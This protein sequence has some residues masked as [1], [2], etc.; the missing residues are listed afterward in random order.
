MFD[1]HPSCHRPRPDVVGD[2]HIAVDVSEDGLRPAQR[3]VHDGDGVYFLRLDSSLSH[4]RAVVSLSDDVTS[5]RL[6]GQER[7]EATFTLVGTPGAVLHLTPSLGEHQWAE[8]RAFPLCDV[9]GIP[10]IVHHVIFL[11]FVIGRASPPVYIRVFLGLVL[12]LGRD[13]RYSCVI[14]RC[15]FRSSES[16]MFDDFSI[17]LSIYLCVCVCVRGI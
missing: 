6:G 13:G 3:P 8:Q 11:T 14:R 2:G 7:F 9:I 4:R 15:G 16:A 5:V 17:Y 12:R 10:D 1:V